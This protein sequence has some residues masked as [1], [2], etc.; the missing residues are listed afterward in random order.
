MAKVLVVDDS[1]FQRS[2]MS[3]LLISAG[4]HVVEAADGA[5]AIHKYDEERPDAVLM[6]VTM[7]RLDGLNALAA[8]RKSDPK[9]RVAMVTAVAQKDTALA[10]IKMGARDFVLKPFNEERVLTAVRRLLDGGH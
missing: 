9:A 8:I 3:R 10:A 5:Q 6:D 2:Q 1:S 7:P 4:Y